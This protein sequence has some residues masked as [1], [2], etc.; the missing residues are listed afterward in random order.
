MSYDLLFGCCLLLFCCLTFVFCFS[1]FLLSHSTERQ[2]Q[3]V[4]AVLLICISFEIAGNPFAVIDDRYKILGRLELATLFVQWATMWCGSMIYASQDPDS[5]GFVV[6][7]T[8]IVATMNIGMLIWLVVRLLMECVRESRESAAAN[9]DGNEGGQITRI[10]SNLQMSIQRWRDGRV[11]EETLQAR[12]RR[13]TVDAADDGNNMSCENPAIHIEMTERTVTAGEVKV[14]NT[15]NDA[16]ADT[17][18]I[19]ILDAAVPNTSMHI[20]PHW[21]RLKLSVN[22]TNHFKRSKDGKISIAGKKKKMKNK[23]KTN[24]QKRAKRLSIVMKAQRD[25][26]AVQNT[27]G[28]NA[29]E[30]KV[31]PPPP[32]KS[33]LLSVQK[34]REAL[35]SNS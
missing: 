12:I 22:T 27:A 1:C 5:K 16:D 3:A 23:S 30:R 2:V 24:Q 31:S 25:S 13:R 7:L 9:E 33:L 18:A 32:P 21:N 14:E 17:T 11:S 15:E 34:T 35:S 4:L 10:M 6:F 29:A 8:V 20:N 19:S 26:V 28:V